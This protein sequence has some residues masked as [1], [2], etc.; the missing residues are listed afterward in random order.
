MQDVFKLEQADHFN[1]LDS[2]EVKKY[3]QR[4]REKVFV[5]KYGGS[6]LR[7]DELMRHF[8]SSVAKLYH[9]GIK[10]ALVHGGGPILSQKME[11]NNIQVT[12][13]NGLR[14]STTETICLAKEVFS[15]INYKICESLQEFSCET[16]PLFRGD[17]VIAHL[18]D[19]T[20]P[21]NRVGK[22]KNIET[23]YFNLNKI[24][25]MSSLGVQEGLQ[26]H[27]PKEEKLLNLNADHL[28]VSLSDYLKA[29]KLIYISDVNGIYRNN[30]DPSSKIDHITI[31]EIEQL[32]KDNTL[33]GG[34]KLKVETAIE[35]LKCGVNK[36]HFID[37]SI[38][39]SLLYEVLTDQG[40]GTEIVHE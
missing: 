9:E 32:I 5:I 3:Y 22:I 15:Q 12:F 17:H 27:L 20:N 40:I 16:Q 8:L 24:P 31:S 36:V 13:E 6:A 39:N 23:K 11:E 14:V 29:R 30:G 25:V 28:A 7:S 4:F 38:K 21:Q 18:V 10:I 26:D 1:Q 37:G 19:P 35:A 34:M 2:R 33:H